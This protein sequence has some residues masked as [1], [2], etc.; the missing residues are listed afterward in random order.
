MRVKGREQKHND[1]ENA[2][3]PSGGGGENVGRLCAENVFRHAP[4]ESRA[5]AFAFR[6]LHQDDEHHEDSNE[7]FEDEQRIDQNGHRDGQY[8]Q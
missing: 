5:Q 3:Q 7:R 4:P 1:K 8:G 6:T 2:R